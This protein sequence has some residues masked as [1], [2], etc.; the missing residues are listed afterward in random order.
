MSLCTCDR[1]KIQFYEGSITEPNSIT[2]L[3]DN[4]PIIKHNLCPLCIAELVSWLNSAIDDSKNKAKA[5]K[6]YEMWNRRAKFLEKTE[7]IEQE[8]NSES[9][10]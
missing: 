7:E 10:T 6:I 4:F 1:C 2:L 8:D 3:H 9:N 5:D